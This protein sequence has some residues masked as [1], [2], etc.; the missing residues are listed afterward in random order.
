MLSSAT[1]ATSGKL[2]LL[3]IDLLRPRLLSRRYPLATLM[4]QI[5]FPR[6]GFH[7]LGGMGSP[8]ITIVGPVVA[9]SLNRSPTVEGWRCNGD[10]ERDRPETHLV[11]RLD[12]P[13]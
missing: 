11:Y 6:G 13:P 3:A 9:G 1:C 7:F 12:E 5:K 8:A 10:G 4:W 2:D